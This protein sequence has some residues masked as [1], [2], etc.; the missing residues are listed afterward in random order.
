MNRKMFLLTTFFILF[1]FTESLSLPMRLIS[2]DT[3]MGTVQLECMDTVRIGS[4]LPSYRLHFICRDECYSCDVYLGNAKDALQ[5]FEQAN[6]ESPRDPDEIRFEDANFDG[7]ID[8]LILSNRGNTTNVDFDFWLFDP[9]SQ[10]FKFS[11]EY[12]TKVACNPAFDPE[13]REI[14]AGG[15]AGCVGMCFE[16]QTFRLQNDSLVLV[17]HFTQRMQTD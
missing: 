14:V 6:V 11:D 3:C 12:S 5:H 8:I 16:F 17:K 9:T 15:A 7:Y 13:K 4:D 1:F 2:S 10:R